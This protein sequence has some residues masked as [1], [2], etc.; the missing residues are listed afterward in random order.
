[1]SLKK[2]LQFIRLANHNNSEAEANLAARKV[3][4]LLKG[5]ELL[6]DTDNKGGAE[7]KYLDID[8][9]LFGTI[10]EKPREPQ[11]RSSPPDRNPFEDFYSDFW[12]RRNKEP[13]KQAP[14]Y[15]AKCKHCK[16]VRMMRSPPGNDWKC[17]TCG[18]F[19][20]EEDH[21][22]KTCKFCSKEVRYR[23][24]PGD[25]WWCHLC[26]KYQNTREETYDNSPPS[27]TRRCSKC[28]KEIK[29]F[30][31]QMQ[32]VNFKCPMCEWKEKVE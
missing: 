22:I 8:K 24:N 27:Y 9:I 19:Q 29:Y 16:N 32:D 20:H 7:P 26:N 17:Y 14:I 5:L 6:R 4:E 2:L 21:I 23:N 30:G 1:M 10:I 18:K 25:N 28:G 12:R 31:R 3:C 15:E 11:F 13:P